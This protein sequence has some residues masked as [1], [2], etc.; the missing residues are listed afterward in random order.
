MTLNPYLVEEFTGHLYQKLGARCEGHRNTI[1]LSPSDVPISL[2]SVI[3]ATEQYF[4]EAGFIVES[5][6]NDIDLYTKNKQYFGFL[7]FGPISSQKM[8]FRVIFTL[9]VL[10]GKVNISHPLARAT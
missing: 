2:G 7:I 1:V 5:T 6:G 4:E 9:F 3:S 8:P 10:T